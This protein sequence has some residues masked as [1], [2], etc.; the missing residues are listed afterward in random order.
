VSTLATAVSRD[1]G[2]LGEVLRASLNVIERDSARAGN[3]LA[4]EEVV[5]L[6]VEHVQPCGL[7]TPR[8]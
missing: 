8:N 3:Q 2:I 7:V 1:I 5:R 6:H 4:R